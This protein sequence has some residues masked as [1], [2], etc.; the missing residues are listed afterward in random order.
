[1]GA[2]W[3]VV[4]DVFTLCTPTGTEPRRLLSVWDGTPAF[5]GV[6][7]TKLYSL[8]LILMIMSS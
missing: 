2:S 4:L 7:D 3:A 6:K 8:T 5:N 1:M